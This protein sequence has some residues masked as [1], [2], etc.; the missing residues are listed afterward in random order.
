MNDDE[1]GDFGR[2]ILANSRE[3][4]SFWYWRDKPVGE[5]GIARDILEAADIEVTDLRSPVKDPPDCEATLDGQFCDIEGT[6]LAHQRTLERSIKAVR[7]RAR[8]EEPRKAEAYIDWGRDGFVEAL[9]DL[10]D[11]KNSKPPARLYE[12]YVPVIH[13]DEF[14]LDSASVQFFLKG[15]TFNTSLITRAF[16]GLSYEPGKGY[17]VFE[18]ELVRP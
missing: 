7:Q 10:L 9:Q 17:P 1:D 4:N 6:E 13:T 14:F 3:W 15:A 8:G 18:L 5:R 16:L 12:R 2:S 11:Q